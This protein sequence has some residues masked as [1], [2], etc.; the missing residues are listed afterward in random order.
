MIFVVDFS[1]IRR[2]AIILNVEGKKWKDTFPND[3]WERYSCLVFADH[4][5]PR[6]LLRMVK[7]STVAVQF[8]HT[9]VIS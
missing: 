7:M 6:Y 3:R 9:R 5:G 4:E 8:V 2:N 1:L